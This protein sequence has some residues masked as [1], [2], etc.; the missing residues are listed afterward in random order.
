MKK[1]F[2]QLA[3]IFVL[4]LICNVS[5][6]Q[7]LLKGTVTDGNSPIAGASVSIKGGTAG[8]STDAR[9]NFTLSV[10]E[11]S[12]VVL[13][14]YIGYLTA[15]IRFTDATTDIGNIVLTSSGSENL[16]E[17]IVV[18]R[19]IIDI[20]ED[21][22]TPIAVSTIKLLEIQEKSAGNVEFPE[23]MK[24]TPSVYIA[25]QASGFGDAKMFVRGFDQSNTAFLLNGQPINGMEDGNMYWS[26]WSAMADVANVIQVQRG[27]GS[28]KLAISSVGGTVNIITKATELN[29]GGYARMMTGNDGYAKATIGYNTGMIG[30][31][32]VSFMLDGWR[33]DRKFARGT[34]GAGQ[35]YFVSV[36]F[37]PNENHNFNFMI[38][39]AP[40]WHDQNFSKPLMTRYNETDNQPTSINT[41]GWD[42][43]GI[44]G[45]SNYGRYDGEGFSARTNFYHK[46]VSNLNWDWT[47]N[48]KSSLSTVLYASVGRGGGTGPLGRGLFHTGYEPYGGGYLSDGS[49]NWAAVAQNNAIL[50][51]GVSGTSSTGA[52]LRAS[53][54]NHF[55]YGLVTNYNFD[56]K[57]YWT[58]NVGADIRMYQGDHFQQLVNLIGAKGVLARPAS[59][60]DGHL[61]SK[62]FST[63]P[64][65]SLFNNAKEGE[66]VGYDNAEKINY[67]GVFGQAEFSKDGFT[68]FIQGSLSNQGYQKINRWNYEAGLTKSE[69]DNKFGYN[70]KG[71]TS[72]TFDGAH[73]LFA[74]VGKYSRQPYLDNV[75]IS[76]TVDFADPSVDNE[77]IF[78]LEAGYKFTNSF[79]RANLN[80]YYTSWDNRFTDYFSQDYAV[81]N[82]EYDDVT[83]LFT[84]IGQLHKGIELDFDAKLLPT[85]NLRGFASI[86]D[87]KYD[88]SSPYRV[89]DADSFDI[90]F[91]DANGQDL[92]GVRVGNAAQ[93]T[94]GLGAKYFILPNFS[95]DAD[96]NYYA[97][98]YANVDIEDVI[99]SSLAGS[100]Y[101]P[102]ELDGFK[103]V[104]GGLSYSFKLRDGQS[105]KFRGNVK[106]IFNEK[107]FARADANGYVYGLGTTWNAGLT[108]SF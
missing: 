26:N 5:L 84:G 43:T 103:T 71:G 94:A 12:G 63:N 19:G 79:L 97:R 67:Q 4:M 6:A 55:W 8:T 39:G 35:N 9:G 31:W 51:D 83:F 15:Q 61:V 58:F 96:F 77:E 10:G 52:V 56:T 13:V 72:Y 108:Y 16:E 7:R 42:I 66:R 95:I 37:K 38:F 28:S 44:K 1:I 29:K 53:V 20:A 73:T 33:A 3:A 75:F 25:D 74:N 68:A 105:I 54:N 69:F 50:A 57:K 46:P 87:W 104:D 62:T 24:H 85:L 21:R 32:G 107:Y 47:I 101:Q 11:A 2:T 90:I 92:T 48:E 30:K 82:T 40:Q 81:G 64:W 41:P 49:A 23:I 106:N 91:E 80:A 86:G 34:A 99:E 102:E 89:R 22:Q 14:K 45:N 60:A 78:G 27:L 98:L 65:S 100:V 59:D 18:G 36:G 76:N 93:T 88:G 17:V 70:I